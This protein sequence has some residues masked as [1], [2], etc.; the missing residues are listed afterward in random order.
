MYHDL[1]G[2]LEH[3][4]HAK[5]APRF[6]K[7]YSQIGRQIGEAIATYKQD[8]RTGAFPSADFSPYKM[9]PSEIAEFKAALPH[10]DLTAAT[11]MSASSSSSLANVK[12]KEP[13]TLYGNK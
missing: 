5:V 1:L 12:A 7:I 11:N 2:L 6:S 8:V 3:E 13:T 10:L 4:H 9:P